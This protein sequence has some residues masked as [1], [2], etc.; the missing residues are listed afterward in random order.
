MDE[1]KDKLNRKGEQV[2]RRIKKRRM[3]S[4]LSL[5]F[6]MFILLLQ[7]APMVTLA[8]VQP[9]QGSEWGDRIPPWQL[10]GWKGQ[11]TKT[12]QQGQL[13]RWELQQ[14]YLQAFPDRPVWQA[15]QWAS[16]QWEL[17]Q[18]YITMNPSASSWEARQWAFSQ[19]QLNQWQAQGQTDQRSWEGNGTEGSSH[20]GEAHQGE[21]TE[22]ANHSGNAHQ[23]EGTEGQA[24]NGK[25]IDFAYDPANDNKAYDLLKFTINDVAGK[26]VKLSTD[27]IGGEMAQVLAGQEMDSLSSLKKSRSW[28]E[29]LLST[30]K[31][32]TGNDIL[33]DVLEGGEAYYKVRDVMDGITDFRGAVI[34]SN[35]GPVDPSDL[36]RLRGT[37]NQLSPGNQAF[38]EGAERF[39]PKVGG[40]L[41]LVGAGFA[42]YETY[43]N[44]TAIGKQATFEAKT[45]MT[46]KSISSA[47]ETI[48]NAGAFVAALPIPGAQAAGAV[49]GIAGGALWLGGL[50]LKWANKTETGR[51]AIRGTVNFVKKGWKKLFG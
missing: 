40:A 9:W 49:M 13:E 17:Q 7:F 51:R 24:G 46:A 16:E 47:G 11:G 27:V 8:Q 35:A 29:L 1:E 18:W 31:V 25:P 19:W 2:V 12:I 5:F 6:V 23:G 28:Q 44:V 10:D 22:G 42:G 43:H 15:E 41:G 4:G 39:I 37:F 36:N 50:G 3:K 34:G 21:G 20:E 33:A 26:T 38:Y 14:W 48:A 45:D 30:A 32:S